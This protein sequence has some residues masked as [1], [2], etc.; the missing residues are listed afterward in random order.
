MRVQVPPSPWPSG[1]AGSAAP[2]RGDGHWFKSSLGHYCGVLAQFGRALVWQTRGRRFDPGILHHGFMAQLGER[3]VRNAEAASS[4]L[5]ESTPGRHRRRREPIAWRT[6]RTPR[7]SGAWSN[8]MTQALQA[9]DE[10]SI[11]SVS[12]FVGREESLPRNPSSRGTKGV[13]DRH[14][15]PHRPQWRG[16]A[17]V[18]R[19]CRVRT[20]GAALRR[21][22]LTAKTRAFQAWNVGSIPS[23][24]STAPWSNGKTRVCKTRVE[25]STPSGASTLPWSNG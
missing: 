14:I 10:G 22:R 5:A 8:G 3:R 1:A 15:M 21:Y 23:T 11:P 17:S 4:S 19:R 25:G 13:P 12:T 24:G 20:P 2:R 7:K 6:E 18:R 16:A 9:W